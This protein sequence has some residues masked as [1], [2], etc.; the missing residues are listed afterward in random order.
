MLFLAY[1]TTRGR[2][3]YGRSGKV[4]HV[5]LVMERLFHAVMKQKL[6]R[7]KTFHHN[8]YSHIPTLYFYKVS[9][10]AEAW[11]FWVLHTMPHG[12]CHRQEDQQT[13]S[14]GAAQWS[15]HWS[16]TAVWWQRYS[17]GVDQ[18]PEKPCEFWQPSVPFVCY[19]FPLWNS[20][21]LLVSLPL[22]CSY[23]QLF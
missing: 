1:H 9:V 20:S 16:S 14:I 8:T 10:T 13:A 15:W 3:Y 6:T 23:F 2:W 11:D 19:P 22:V 7:V 21:H 4:L 5:S 18:G 17:P 12:A